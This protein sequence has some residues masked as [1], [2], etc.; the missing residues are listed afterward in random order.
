VSD[1]W[2]IPEKGF[3]KYSGPSANDGFDPLDSRAT[4]LVTYLRAEIQEM[5]GGKS[6]ERHTRPE[7]V[8]LPDG[9]RG[10]LQQR[11]ADDWE[12][13]T[14]VRRDFYRVYSARTR[15]GVLEVAGCPSLK[16]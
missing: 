10:I 6:I 13:V 11:A 14:H 7:T 8:V 5:V 9:T 2:A 3:E 16:T 1:P 4:E 15:E 12:I